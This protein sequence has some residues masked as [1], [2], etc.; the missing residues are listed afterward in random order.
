MAFAPVEIDDIPDDI[1]DQ[2]IAYVNLTP[3]S[4]EKYGINKEEFIT[5][6]MKIKINPITELPYEVISSGLRVDGYEQVDSGNIR[7]FARD[8]ISEYPEITGIDND[9]LEIY[10]A[11]FLQNKW[12]I[13][14]W[15][16]EENTRFYDSRI[17]LR[18]SPD[19]RVFYLRSYVV[20]GFCGDFRE[21]SKDEAE[22][23]ALDFLQMH[24]ADFEFRDDGMVILPVLKDSSYELI[25]GR[26]FSLFSHEIPANFRFVVSNDGD[27]IRFNNGL[28]TVTG[29]VTGMVYPRNM[30]TPRTEMPWPDASIS[31][32]GGYGY[33]NAAGAYSAGSGSGD[34]IFYTAMTGRWC[35]INVHSGSAADISQTFTGTTFDFL[36]TDS[37]ARPDEMNVYYHV[38]NVHNYV[39]DV[40]GW[41]GMDYQM[42]ATVGQAF[43]N[44]Y[45]DG[46]DINMGAGSSTFNNLGYFADI[47]QHEFHHGVTGSIYGSISGIYEGMGMA[48]NEAFSDYFPCAMSDE[49]H[50][51]EGGLY[52]DGSP[53]MRTIDNVRRYPEDYVNECH[54]DGQILSG[55]LWDFRCMIDDW[56]VDSLAFNARFGY[57]LTFEEYLTELLICDDSDGDITNGTNHGWDM[58][59]AFY[60]H[61]I[62]PGGV[63]LVH[64]PITFADDTL[65]G[66]KIEAVLESYFDLSGC[67][68][69]LTY[70]RAYTDTGET[71]MSYEDGILIGEI[72]ASPHGT[73]I[74]YNIVVDIGGDRTVE[75]PMGAPTAWHHFRVQE[76]T[77]PPTL[78]HTTTEF[79]MQSNPILITASAEDNQGIDNLTLE[80]K[81]NSI[82]KPSIEMDFDRKAGNYYTYLIGDFADGDVIE[83]KITA[84][85]L[86]MAELSASSP[87]SGWHEV[88]IGRGFFDPIGPDD[89]FW[90]SYPVSSGYMNQWHKSTSED[91]TGLDGYS[92]KFGAE[93]GHDYANGA[94]GALELD[95]VHLEG[96]SRLIFRHKMNAEADYDGAWDGGVVEA[97]AGHGWTRIAP[98]SGWHEL[99]TNRD[100]SFYP[101]GGIRVYSGNNGWREE[102]IDL[103]G[104]EGWVSFRFRFGS[105]LYVTDEGWYIDNVRIET[106]FSSIEYE[107]DGWQT[108]EKLE[109]SASPNPFN[110]ATRI[111]FTLG[112]DATEAKIEIYDMLGNR[113]EDF[114]IHTKTGVNSVNWNANDNVAGIYLCKLTAGNEEIYEKLI[115]IK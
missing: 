102:T 21:I 41:D 19:A 1:L 15:Q 43:D 55:A 87:S 93:S 95:A 89:H 45:F 80:W 84:I 67:T 100:R 10:R 79:R 81:L 78:S 96:S 48:M 108:P 105:D 22:T 112:N 66:Y 92:F 77:E 57:P 115:Y 50:V 52:T 60:A 33:T 58:V 69:T 18:V 9:N 94:E 106:D 26:K 35:R 28:T 88:V 75:T 90:T 44:A 29:N 111:S 3:K 5:K 17:E 104:I 49:P 62:G 82:E 42:R 20:P 85:D 31:I 65:L 12:Y 51:G 83:Y 86:S 73:R 46:R 74:D 34:H 53:Y 71:E 101:A 7:D 38:S 36:W 113:I 39:K 70:V 2:D 25:K 23:A 13:T 68:A 27:I 109:L 16:Y 4:V 59:D 110:A 64:E 8:F 97:S 11:E 107:E 114:D 91:D 37:Y 72:P 103:T 61:G 24:Y 63:S 56:T 30:A 14:F 54:Y 76:D 47:V 99:I 6:R 98:T 40:F 32:D